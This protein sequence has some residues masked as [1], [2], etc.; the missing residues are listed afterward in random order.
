MH[1]AIYPFNGEVPGCTGNGAGNGR[2]QPRA[3]GAPGISR[4][5]RG[6]LEVQRV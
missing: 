6:F 1:T 4:H 2:L 5:V 3:A